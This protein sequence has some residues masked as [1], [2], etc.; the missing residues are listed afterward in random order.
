MSQTKSFESEEPCNGQ[1]KDIGYSKGLDK[2]I[3]SSDAYPMHIATNAKY[4]EDSGKV[5]PCT[6]L[7]RGVAT[8]NV[9]GKY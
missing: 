3:L 8:W 7:V 9:H 4:V 5:L 1:D 6:T 2:R